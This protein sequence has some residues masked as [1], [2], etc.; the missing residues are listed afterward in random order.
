[1]DGGIADCQVLIFEVEH[2]GC[3]KCVREHYNC[4]ELLA[5][6]LLL[7]LTIVILQK[8]LP[9]EILLW[10]ITTLF[11]DLLNLLRSFGF[12]SRLKVTLFIQLR[13]AVDCS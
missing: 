2:L 5:L 6:Q 1:M 7:Q 11:L 3:G 10:L 9:V 4:I 13:I 8:I 12:L